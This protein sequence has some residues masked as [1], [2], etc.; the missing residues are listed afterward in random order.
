[1]QFSVEWIPLVD[2]GGRR[3]TPAPRSETIEAARLEDLILSIASTDGWQMV[4]EA[5]IYHGNQ[6]MLTIRKGQALTAVQ[7]T[8]DPFWRRPA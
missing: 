7:V 5:S 6:A 3:I 8:A 2:E 1:M 4:G